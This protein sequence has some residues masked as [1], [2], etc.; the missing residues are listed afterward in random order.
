MLKHY[1]SKNE[2]NGYNYKNFAIYHLKSSFLK[3]FQSISIR[4]SLLDEDLCLRI[5]NEYLVS[6]NIAA[7]VS[8]I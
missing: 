5:L 6:R 2:T 4:M 1:L 3:T 8:F 7:L